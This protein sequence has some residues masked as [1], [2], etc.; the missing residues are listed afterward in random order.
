MG[1]T[2]ANISRQALYHLSHSPSLK[3]TFLKAE[4]NLG[5]CKMLL[6]TT[7]ATYVLLSKKNN[8]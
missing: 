4:S 3:P 5:L 7:L 2:E 8:L 6:A 1:H